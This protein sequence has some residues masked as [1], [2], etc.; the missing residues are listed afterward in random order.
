[1][2]DR[3]PLGHE[4]VVV[5]DVRRCVECTR[6]LSRAK[7]PTRAD[8]RGVVT[9]VSDAIAKELA[10]MR[11]AIDARDEEAAAAKKESV[12]AYRERRDAR[13]AQD[14][15]ATLREERIQRLGRDKRRITPADFE[16]VVSPD[17]AALE[18]TRSWFVVDKFLASG[19][20]FCVL[21]GPKGVGKTVAAC[22]AKAR[23]GGM[24]V[25]ADEMTRAVRNEH[26]EA[27]ALRRAMEEVEFL[28]VDDLGL[29]LDEVV[30]VR[31][32]QHVVNERQ[33]VGMRTLITTN[34]SVQ[35]LYDRYDG[36]TSERITHGGAFVEIGGPSRRRLA[37]P[38]SVAL[39]KG[40]AS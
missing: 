27:K 1:M 34:L 11:A 10:D 23:L 32:L 40:S 5:G 6:A 28:V 33:G 12:E 38:T 39:K 4:I 16:R 14:E 8:G 17:P 22:A 2:A 19:R 31:A 29:E 18:V 3:C 35:M 9:K 7:P 15:A 21:S 20:N 36:R 24:I 13:I 30:G 25:S 26:D 37:P